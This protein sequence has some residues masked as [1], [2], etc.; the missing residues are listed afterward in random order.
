ML[1]FD[2]KI[3]AKKVEMQKKAEMQKRQENAEMQ[4]KYYFKKKNR[5]KCKKRL[6]KSTGWFITITF[7]FGWCVSIAEM[8]ELHWSWP[9]FENKNLEKKIRK[10]NQ[11][12]FLENYTKM[13]KRAGIVF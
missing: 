12:Y 8:I 10:K 2:L 13:L 4:R 3:Q 1:F 6:Q 11:N 5:Q 9:E 7:I